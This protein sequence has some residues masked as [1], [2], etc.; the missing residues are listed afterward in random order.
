MCSVNNISTR[1][2]VAVQ[3]FRRFFFSKKKIKKSLP[4]S[5][6]PPLCRRLFRPSGAAISLILSFKIAPKS[7]LNLLFCEGAD[8]AAVCDCKRGEN[9]FGGCVQVLK[10][11]AD[12]DVL[13]G[14]AGR[15]EAEYVG[16][17]DLWQKAWWNV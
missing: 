8:P 1:Q 5:R 15:E 6:V 12:C 7:L 3:K 14:N 13:E 9:L 17:A 11:L 16:K 2:S 10:I 4:F